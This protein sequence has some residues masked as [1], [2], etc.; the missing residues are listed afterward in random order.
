M[1]RYADGPSTEV[2][3]L[4]DA[5]VTDVWP[6]LCDINVPGSFSEEFQRA[7]WLDDGPALGATFRGFNHHPVVGEWSAVCTVTAMEESRVFEW[8]VGDV[9]FKAARWR[10]DLEPDGETSSVLK[11][12]SEIGPA[13]SGL[14]PA[15]ERMPD[16]EEDIVAKRMGEHNT[17]MQ[18]TIDGIKKLVEGARA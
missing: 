9:E 7:E 14:T 2:T 12:S 16:R 1:V 18:R 13:P 4:I 15:I 8:T 10:F 6:Y 3:V 11:F 5:S 17:N